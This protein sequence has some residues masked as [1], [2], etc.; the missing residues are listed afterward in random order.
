MGV[1]PSCGRIVPSTFV[2]CGSWTIEGQ[3]PLADKWRLHLTNEAW[4]PLICKGWTAL[5]TLK[6]EDGG[7]PSSV[8]SGGHL[9]FKRDVF[10]LPKCI[11]NQLAG[12][13][14]E[15]CTDSSDRSHQVKEPQSDQAKTMGSGIRNQSADAT[16][17]SHSDVE[18]GKRQSDQDDEVEDAPGRSAILDEAFGFGG[19][20]E[21]DEIDKFL[22][23]EHLNEALEDEFGQE[24]ATLSGKVSRSVMKLNFIFFNFERGLNEEEF[25]A[26]DVGLCD[27]AIFIIIVCCSGFELAFV[28]TNSSSRCGTIGMEVNIGQDSI[29]NFERQGKQGSK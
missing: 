16:T 17:E 6:Y 14:N 1:R 15:R 22:R 25:V 9:S 20:Q 7:H 24:V 21:D 18:K 2:R 8:R 27:A 12:A 29:T 4:Q 23:S 28:R 5:S 3:T 26:V 10:V 13:T 11:R 19:D